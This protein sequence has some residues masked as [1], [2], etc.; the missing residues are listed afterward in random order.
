MAQ[1]NK[2]EAILENIEESYF[3]MKKMKWYYSHK[4][5]YEGHDDF[6]KLLQI[7]TSAKS[8]IDLRRKDREKDPRGKI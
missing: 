6:L 4:I 5:F 3:Y 2:K 7:I 1:N 8:K